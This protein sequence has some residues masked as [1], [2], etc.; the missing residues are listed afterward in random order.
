MNP[1]DLDIDK[2]GMIYWTDSSTVVHL[3]DAVIEIMGEPTGRLLRY[4]PSTNESTV[5]LSGLHFANGVQLSKNEEFVL[6]A[7]T[8]R[9]RVLK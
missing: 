5:L 6:V 2:D 3:E 4:D 7:E 8:A 1:N 9:C